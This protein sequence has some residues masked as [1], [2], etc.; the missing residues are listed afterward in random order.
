VEVFTHRNWQHC[1][2]AGIYVFPHNPFPN[3][4][5]T[6]SFTMGKDHRKNKKVNDSK[7]GSFI[8]KDRPRS[9]NLQDAKAWAVAQEEAR[10]AAVKAAAATR[11]IHPPTASE[12]KKRGRQTGPTRTGSA[13]TSNFI[14]S[15]SRVREE[16]ARSTK[17]N[18]R[19]SATATSATSSTTAASSTPSR[20]SSVAASTPIG[21]AQAAAALM[22]D[23]IPAPLAR[24]WEIADSIRPRSASASIAFSPSPGNYS[25]LPDWE[26]YRAAKTAASKPTEVIGTAPI[27]PSTSAAKGTAAGSMPP[28]PPLRGLRPLRLMGPGESGGR[29]TGS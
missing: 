12:A 7:E 26:T 23:S 21:G 1:N 27:T 5:L 16:L 18:P 29:T 6:F 28:P 4:F 10:E 9:N 13:T 24:A 15:A 19:A 3:H 20:S 14:L 2:S 25:H 11:S 22:D 17:P 8:V